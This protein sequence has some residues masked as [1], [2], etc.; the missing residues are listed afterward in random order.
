[1][2]MSNVWSA[3][4]MGFSRHWL[5]IKW[6]TTAFNEVPF[7]LLSKVGIRKKGEYYREQ[8]PDELA[9]D[10]NGTSRSERLLSRL[11]DMGMIFAVVSLILSLV[12]LVW[13]AFNVVSDII[14]LR[15]GQNA[16]PVHEEIQIV[17]K[18]GSYAS[19]ASQNDGWV[20]KF[21]P[22]VCSTLS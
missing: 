15:S 21:T 13:G 9:S 6:E 19:A 16:I 22:L 18:R 7:R 14:R 4:G 17:H 11:Y 8:E 2:E 20:P 1:M 3:N 12:L 5:W 10:G